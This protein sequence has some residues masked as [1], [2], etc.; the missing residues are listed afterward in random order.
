MKKVILKVSQIL[1]EKTRIGF[2]LNNVAGLIPATLLK[3]TPTQVF[4]YEI[5]EIFKNTC[6]EEHLQATASQQN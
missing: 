3:E 4:S 6:F 1:Q 5:Y 2:S